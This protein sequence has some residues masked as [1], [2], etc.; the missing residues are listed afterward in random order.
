MKKGLLLALN[1]ALLLAIIWTALLWE[2]AP[3][4]TPL[5]GTH[6]ARMVADVPLPPPPTGGDFSLDGPSGPVA[7]RDF[8][9]KVVLLYFGYTYCPDICPTSL[10]VWQ[11]ALESLSP[12][13]LARVQPLFVSVDPER[14]GLERLVEYVRFFHPRIVALTG[15]PAS[16]AEIAGR[17]GAVFVR[18]ESASAGGYVIDHSALTYVIDPQGRLVDALPHGATPGQLLAVLRKYLSSN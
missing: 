12:Q 10:T 11:Q 9:G 15:R 1:I 16:L 13:E 14:D 2:P 4:R 6:A 7:L 18:Q 5:P 17:Y 8:A 3:D